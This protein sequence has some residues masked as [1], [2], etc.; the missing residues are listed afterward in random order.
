MSG[1]AGRRGLDDTGVVII[2]CNDSVPEVSMSV[3]WFCYKTE[4]LTF[5]SLNPAHRS[6]S[7]DSRTAYKA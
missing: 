7:N 4:I 1:R 3:P 5:R 6:E 2:A